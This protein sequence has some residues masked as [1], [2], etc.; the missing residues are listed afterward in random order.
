MDAD[1]LRRKAIG[2]L[3]S[4]LPEELFV[5]LY[6]DRER[7]GEVPRLICLRSVSHEI[8]LCLALISV[9]TYAL[10]LYCMQQIK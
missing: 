4:L 2:Q 3:E 1:L 9:G 10:P 8:L 6:T 5:P 7:K